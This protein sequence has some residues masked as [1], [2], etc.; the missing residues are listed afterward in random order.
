MYLTHGHHPSVVSRCLAGALL[1]LVATTQVHAADIEVLALFRDQAVIRV[2]GQRYK[3][4]SGESTPEGVRLVSADATGVV[5]E[6][7]GVTRSYPL[8]AKLR[9][10]YR[11]TAGD[12][13]RVYRDPQGMF[14]TVGSIKGMPVTFLV[15]TGATSI[16][17][18]A[19][20]ARRLGIDFRVEGERGAVM[21]A[22][23]AEP[24][25]RVM[26]DTV[27][28]GTIQLHN[29]EAVVLDGPQPQQTLLGM[30]FL[31][32]LDMQNDGEHLT[33]RRKY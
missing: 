9:T 10:G 32:R 20:Q 16:A 7:A 17:M 6:H 24:V 30:S 1:L 18:N 29:V 13:V 27:R 22:S 21:T 23:R 8:G 11:Q 3:L 33:L 2:D 19:A 26:L 14:T 15:D 5:L 12:E 4:A 28:V 31:G 25:Y